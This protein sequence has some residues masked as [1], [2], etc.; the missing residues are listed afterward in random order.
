[1]KDTKHSPLGRVSAAASGVVFSGRKAAS[2]LSDFRRIHGH[3]CPTVLDPTRYEDHIATPDAPFTLD[4]LG[5]LGEP[6]LEEALALL[7]CSPATLVLTPS[8]FFRADADGETAIKEAA[9]RIDDLDTGNV[10]LALPLEAA[11]LA[12]DPTPLVEILRR[13]RTPKALILGGKG[14][15]VSSVA[16]AE[17]LRT[18]VSHCPDTALLRSDLAGVDA[19]VHGAS[20]SSIG[21]TSSTRYT[22]LPWGRPWS[23]KPKDSSPNVLNPHLLDW[24]R[25]SGLA[26]YADHELLWCACAFCTGWAADRNRQP[27]VRSLGELHDP[28]DEP[29]ARAH[30]MAVWSELWAYLAHDGSRT[31]ARN[32]WTRLCSDAVDRHREYDGRLGTRFTRFRA[33]SVLRHW[34]G[35]STKRR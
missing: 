28:A 26:E 33:P 4:G 24:M 35:R 18:I 25:G 19:M 5:V 14:N 8:G 13:T 29:D 15:P 16:K 30:N 9:R 7:T 10:V 1:M 23:P 3:D 12:G 2:R 17:A 11:W 22:P 31:G 34:A 27:P 20:F 6:S 32:R 21:D